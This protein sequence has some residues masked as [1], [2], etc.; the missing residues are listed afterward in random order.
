MSLEAPPIGTDR[1]TSATSMTALTRQDTERGSEDNVI[2]TTAIPIRE[3][4]RCLRAWLFYHDVRAF[5][6]SWMPVPVFIFWRFF[7]AVYIF[8]WLIAHI[9]AR[10]ETFG[11][12]WFIYLT[13]LAY[14]LLTIGTI[15]MA[16]LNVWYTILHYA[17]PRQITSYIPQFEG[18]PKTVYRKDNI[19][20]FVKLCWMLYLMGASLA[21]LVTA[22]YW[23]LVYRPGCP[24]SSSEMNNTDLMMNADN[25]TLPPITGGTIACDDDIDVYTLHF[26]GIN[27]IIILFDLFVS[28]IPYQFMH[29]FYPLFFMVPYVLFTAIYWGAG[30]T[31][32]GNEMRYIYES[33][34]YSNA[35]AVGW[36][37]LLIL[38]PMPVHLLMFLLAWLRDVISKHV[39]CCYRDIMERSY[40][41]GASEEAKTNDGLSLIHI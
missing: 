34:D 26:H 31:N 17:F 40:K 27:A 9:V 6:T 38:A 33:L 25:S 5:V 32:P 35:S 16:I 3:E 14:L 30:G 8:V 4:F 24:T 13:D 11:P 18:D 28:R 1:Q 36:A 37:L 21:P 41:V 23:I 29:F 2:V 39:S 10:S 19:P 7:V 12:R 20:W 15:A 22:G